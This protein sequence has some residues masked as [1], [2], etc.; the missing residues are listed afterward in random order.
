MF[1]AE[2]YI[3]FHF[4]EDPTLKRN[5]DCRR[6]DSA[7]ELD[8]DADLRTAVTWLRVRPSRPPDNRYE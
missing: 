6:R 7:S 8:D 3:S 5:Y 4:L 2:A 1:S